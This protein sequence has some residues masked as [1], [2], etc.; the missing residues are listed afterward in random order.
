M[1]RWGRTESRSCF[2]QKAVLNDLTSQ[3]L[4]DEV[5][6][7]TFFLV[8]E[9]IEVEADCVLICDLIFQL[10]FNFTKIG[11]HAGYTWSRPLRVLKHFRTIQV[12]FTFSTV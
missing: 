5:A 11:L 12:Q 6:G 4:Y 1:Q 2:C 9:M 3:L 10:I 8:E 7:D